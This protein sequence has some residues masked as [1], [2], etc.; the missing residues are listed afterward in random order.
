MAVQVQDREAIGEVHARCGMYA[1]LAWAW[2]Y[3]DDAT[4]LMLTEIVGK[5]SA[6]PEAS[7]FLDGAAGDALQKLAH[8]LLVVEYECGLEDEM[9][10]RFARLFGHAVRGSCPLYELE[11]GQS[12][13][14]QQA[15]E[16]ADIAG[17]YRAFGLEPRTSAMERVDHASAELEFM[18]VLCAKEAFGLQSENA[19][20]VEA[21]QDGQRAFLRDHLS[22]WLPAFCARVVKADEDGVY[23]AAAGLG[24]AFIEAECA[25][26]GITA[27]PAFLK[28]R[29]IDPQTDAEISCGGSGSSEQLVPLTIE[30]DPAEQ[31]T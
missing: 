3:P 6:D 25:R 10:R 17:F 9:R 23:G 26:F 5:L 14:V 12:E 20:L 27:G 28:L 11:Y 21:V 30:G 1:L 2:R 16:L 29:P 18:G 24:R 31:E 7:S 19:E 15:S 22:R 13:I 8:R 4:V